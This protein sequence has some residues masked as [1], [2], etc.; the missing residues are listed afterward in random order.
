MKYI[1]VHLREQKISERSV[2]RLK[3]AAEH[4]PC[5]RFEIK[6]VTGE[7]WDGHEVRALEERGLWEVEWLE[8]G[9]VEHQGGWK[10]LGLNDVARNVIRKW[11]ER[12]AR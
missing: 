4:A 2:D 12:S 11:D 5:G 9:D 6:N 7:L 3:Y 1:D 10:V 8:P